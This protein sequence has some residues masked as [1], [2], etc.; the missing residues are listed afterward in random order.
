MTGPIRATRQQV[1]AFRLAGHQLLARRPLHDIKDVAGACGIRNTPPG[2]SLLALHARLADLTPAVVDRA[3]GESKTLV[4]VLGM[5]IA[6]H[7]VP[8]SHV[9]AFTLG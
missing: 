5:R 4:E 1:L 6:P 2:S 8:T 9:S 3:L 7:L